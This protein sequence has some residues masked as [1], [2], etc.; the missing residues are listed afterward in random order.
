M[1]R[2]P[3]ATAA[4][5]SGATEKP[6]D[7]AI[8]T[9]V[10]KRLPAFVVVDGNNDI[11]R[12]SGATDRFLGPTPGAASLNLFSLLR[13]GLR[14]P[15]RAVLSKAR[16]TEKEAKYP[17]APLDVDGPPQVV[18]L[19]AEA[20]PPARDGMCILMFVER[21]PDIVV[22]RDGGSRPRASAKSIDRELEEM[23]GRM[24]AAVDQFENSNQELKSANEEYQAVNEELQS[25]NEELETSKEELQ[26][27]NEELQT[28]NAE[29]I[30]KSNRLQEVN[31][32]LRNLLD[33]TQIATLFL[34]RQ[35]RIR[36]F[37]PAMTTLLHL[38][39][40]D[41]GRPVTDLVNRLA[42]DE[43]AADAAK[44]QKQLQV[45]EREVR[46]K[47][48]DTWF[49]VR[50]RPYQTADN[51]IDGVVITCVDITER[52]RAADLRQHLID[53]L[54]HRV[55]NTL[56]SVRAIVK[57]TLSKETD[58]ETVR[59]LDARLQS[60]SKT[61]TLL[62]NSQWAA[63]SLRELLLQELEPYQQSGVQRVALDGPELKL[64]PSAS[65]I[66]AMAFHELVTNAGAST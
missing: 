22:T 10:E 33:S 19:C 16:A 35:L 32:D 44:V 61:H 46:V 24:E 8:R 56:A 29:M 26:S 7:V 45:V 62:T 49:L 55:R 14:S 43:M 36:N 60:L 5:S 50:L 38:R 25:T 34:D 57:R 12:F 18:D 51:I 65:L 59:T 54:N 23:R 53:E 20:L 15:A 42:Y 3:V 40:S 1:F 27:V 47:D 58:A 28:V 64:N 63:T 6:L 2:P 4:A 17:R 9:L 31:D 30:S 52:K 11:V 21:A 13:R 66:L 48:A 39:E 41:Q 37:T